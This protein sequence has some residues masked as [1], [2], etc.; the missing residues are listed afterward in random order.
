MAL[1]PPDLDD[2][3][4]QNIV[5]EA[6]SRIPAY[7]NGWTDHNVSDPGVTLIELFA[8]M[9][10]LILYR[11]NQVPDRLYVKMMEM[12][13]LNLQPPQ[14]AVADVTFQLSTPSNTSINIKAGTE[15][16]T[17]QTEQQSAIIFTTDEP[18]TIAPPQ[19]EQVI[20]YRQGNQQV[21]KSQIIDRLRQPGE[22]MN[23]FSQ[24]PRPDDALYFGFSDAVDLSRHLLEFYFDCVEGHGSGIDETLPPLVWE[25]AV[26]QDSYGELQWQ[27]CAVELDETRGLN[28]PGRIQVHC[29]TFEPLIIP[30]SDARLCWL[31]LRVLP[32]DAYPPP[33]PRR[34]RP[35]V[36][37][38]QVRQIT[39]HTIGGTVQATQSQTI[40]REMLGYSSGLPGQTFHLQSAPLLPPD[41]ARGE[42]LVVQLPNNG[43]EETWELQPAFQRPSNS[44]HVYQFKQYTLD[45]A[46]GEIRLPPAQ[47]L[48]DGSVL[49]YGAIPPRGASI[50]FNSYRFGGGSHGNVAAY[51]LN[52]LKTAVPQINRVYNRQPA[53]GGQDQETLDAAKL[54]APHALHARNRAVTAADFE[55]H[56]RQAGVA[57]GR[58]KC[59]QPEPGWSESVNPGVVYLLLLPAV[60]NPSGRLTARE[61][62]MPQADRDRVETHLNQRRLLTTRLEVVEATLIPVSAAVQCRLAPGADKSTLYEAILARLH[63][64]LNPLAGGPEETGWPFGRDLYTYDVYHCLQ[65]LP[66][67][68]AIPQITLRQP[69]P[70]G[71]Y[72]TLPDGVLPIPPHATL[73]SDVHEVTFV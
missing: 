20:T 51:E 6:K 56:A 14:A 22:V 58:V 43:K 5:D 64:Y 59:L 7:I 44:Q 15:V 61:L 10:E 18:L 40:K 17:T 65:N 32:Q 34:M 39:V 36:E 21:T 13:G 45:V 3:T 57:L 26:S 24:K 28:V 42:T 53:R 30:F 60:K 67:V 69:R 71:R 49:I 12:M 70:N 50:W 11:Q 27:R 25:T 35:Y 23:L 19:L 38:P 62:V 72:Q 47:T 46:S 2:R 37:T 31:R 29:H 4:F 48:A 9:T 1:I 8:W 41:P 33:D 55:H 52:T 54:R 63:A 16:A 68:L 66:G 73:I